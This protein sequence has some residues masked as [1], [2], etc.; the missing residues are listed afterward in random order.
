MPSFRAASTVVSMLL[1]STAGAHAADRLIP[2]RSLAMSAR[3]GRQQLSFTAKSPLIAT[4]GSDPRT[5]GAV[6]AIVVADSGESATIDLPASRWTANGNGTA[7]KFK[8]PDAPAGPSAVKVALLK[9]G[10]LKVKARSTGISLNEPSQSA[11]GLVLT[12]GD[13]RYCALF[14]GIIKR[15]QPGA[16]VAKNAPAPASCPGGVATPRDGVSTDVVMPSSVDGANIAFTVHEPTTFVEGRKYPL[17]LEGHGYGGNRIAA[18]ER[19]A[20][21]GSDTFARLLDAGYGIISVDQRGH[22]GSGGRI[23]ILDP[24]FEGRDL[25]QIVDW[26]E[27]ALSWLAYRDGNLLL[28]ATGGSYGG[29]FQHILYAHDPQRRLDAIAPEIT[30]HDLRSALFSGSV[31]KS[32]WAVALSAAGTATPGGQDP[33]VTAGLIQGLTTNSLTQQQL[34][35][36]KA[37]SLITQCEAGTL[38]PIDALY[39]QSASDTLFNL[40]EA[41]HN[42][43][44]VAAL[45][46]DVRLLT[47]NGGHDSLFPGIG[48]FNTGEQ[49]GA[50]QKTQSIVDWYDEKLRGMAGHADYIPRTCF[51]MDATVDDGVVTDGVPAGGQAFAIPSTAVL[52]QDASPLVQ[53]IVLTVAG[54]NGAV[55]AGIPTIQLQV[56]DPLGLSLGDP[57]V[58]VGLARRAP[59]ALLDTLLQANQVRPFRGYGAFDDELIGAT[60]RLAP[61]EELRLLIHASFVPRYVGSGTDVA[62][63][64]NVSG[65]VRVPVLAANLPAPPAN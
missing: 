3:S 62:A 50:L 26:A 27:G 35:L 18:A 36:L 8:N 64:V 10:S 37:S 53:S 59:G 61:G 15:N 29:G 13:T 30:W 34:D 43:A 21:G 44:C 7:Y 40:N 60:A 25:V 28:G 52:A 63:L 20:P 1:L 14:G 56:A 39:W 51:H 16:F 48:G 17:I 42:A 65:T 5:T 11:I 9:N 2:G 49:C 6:L 46:G 22:G 55:V 4:N 12:T 31:F 33:E 57:I 41:V 32:F 19:P 38:P 58:F 45:G 24:N 23:R 54:P 47:K